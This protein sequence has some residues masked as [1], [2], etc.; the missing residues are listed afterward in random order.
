MCVFVV[1]FCLLLF[2]F[3]IFLIIFFSC[4][5]HEMG[6][7]SG[8]F[9]TPAQ[10]SLVHELGAQECLAIAHFTNW[11]TVLPSNSAAQFMNW[12]ISQTGRN[13]CT[14]LV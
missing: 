13:I 2:I 14:G 7:H 10:N 3:C 12:T 4:S 8:D 5:V 9:K 11:A 1:F 6:S